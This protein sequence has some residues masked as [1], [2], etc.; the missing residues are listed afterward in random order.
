[1]EERGVGTTIGALD[2]L[3]EESETHS[4]APRDRVLVVEDD[5][6]TAAMLADVLVD[7]G[8]YVAI[9]LDSPFGVRAA[10][11][12]VRPAAIILDLKLP[13]RSG[14]LLLEDLKSDP[15]TASVPVVVVSGLAELLPREQ[16]SLAAAV[17]TKPVTHE[18]LLAAVHEASSAGSEAT[19]ACP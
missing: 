8:G 17:L 12:R 5:P 4:A 7:A 13:Y 11:R 3:T 10:V 1:M 14:A 19:D 9:V 15:E 6:A 16:A 18:T 2:W